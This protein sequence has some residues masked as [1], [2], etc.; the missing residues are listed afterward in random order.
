VD[1]DGT[2]WGERAT[3]VQRA[4][5]R[6]LLD[7]DGPRRHWISR[8]RGYSK[9]DDLAAVT[10]VVLLEELQSG[11]EAIGCAADRDQA[12]ILVDRVRRIAQRTPELGSAL[13][14]GAYDV[15]TAGGVRFEAMAADAASAWG[16]S[17]SWVVVD[18]LCQWSEAENAKGMW[19]AVATAVPKRRGRLA[20]ITT[21]GDPSHWSRDVYEFAVDDDLWR[22]SETHG[23]APWLDS[24]ELASERRRLPESAWQRFFE[25]RWAATEDRL[26][27]FEDLKACALLPGRLD[28][29]PGESY[30]LGVDLAVRRDNAVVAVCHCEQVEGYGD[31]RV[32]VDSLDVFIPSRQ[33]EV[34]LMA[35]EGC[36]QARSAQYGHALAIFDPAQGFQMMAR[37]RAAGLTVL[38]HTFSARTNSRRALL[39]LELVRGRRLWLPDDPETITEFAAVRLRETSPGVYRYDHDSGKH[40]DRVTAISLGA[41]HLLEKPVGGSGAPWFGSPA[42]SVH[43]IDGSFYG[44]RPALVQSVAP[45]PEPVDEDEEPPGHY[46]DAYGS[47]PLAK[48][49]WNVHRRRERERA[50]RESQARRLGVPSRPSRWRLDG[51]DGAR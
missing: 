49:A 46:L 32:V 9:T 19:Q 25:N 13:E 30:V 8:S 11:D 50:L 40:D 28:P 31:R 18:E 4:D 34:D 33:H 1:D 2:R 6:A 45:E 17:P 10:A 7:L 15:R 48:S 24:D 39:I 26:L 36:V 20:V 29:E 38:E 12:R 5:A 16:R 51:P 27:T 23:P 37:L 35:V 43:D 3:G 44:P 21:S 42:R 14:I 47:L 41:L 22:V